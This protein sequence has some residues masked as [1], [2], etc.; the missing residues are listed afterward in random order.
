MTIALPAY[1]VH[2][3]TQWFHEYAESFCNTGDAGLDDAV[4]LKAEHTML[5]VAEMAALCAS[6]ELEARI[7]HLG[8]IAALLHD[9]ARF[10]QFRQYRTFSDHRSADHALMGVE[11]IGKLRLLD[12]V[13]HT[14]AQ[15][16]I[17]A[18]RFHNAPSVPAGLS[19][20]GDLLCRLLRD[21]DKLDIYRIT[22]GY[23]AKPDPNRKDTI[24]VG[25]ADGAVISPMVIERLRKREVVP[26]NLITTV[27][28]FKLIQLGWIYDLNFSG[29]LA[30][31]AE[32]GYAGR[33]ASF[34]PDTPEVREIV[35]SVEGY[36]KEMLDSGRKQLF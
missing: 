25:V 20:C 7:R 26:Y 14:D 6:A 9:V 5:V 15:A 19:G 18:I 32:R 13:A 1:P 4:R 16:I 33:I 8:A 28:D 27:A 17:E 2:R 21:A 34:L 10:E 31:V 29:S 35:Q 22:T 24:Q 30:R 36:I 3:L 11:L 23:F 12:D